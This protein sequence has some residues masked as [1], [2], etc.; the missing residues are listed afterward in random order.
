MLTPEDIKEHKE[1]IE[2]A[3]NISSK[4]QEITTKVK[5]E[6]Q[7]ALDILKN[8]GYTSA[9]DIPSLQ[10]D[11]ADLEAEIRQEKEEAEKYI[12]EGS[13]IIEETDEITVGS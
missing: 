5:I 12:L 2:K 3:N 1:L 13:K 7:R 10:K 6:K 11:L 9:S 8:N 4:L